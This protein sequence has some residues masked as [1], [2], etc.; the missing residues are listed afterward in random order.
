[1][2]QKIQKY[3]S[4]LQ[5]DKSE[6]TA[7]LETMSVAEL[8]TLAG[9]TEKQYSDNYKKNALITRLLQF[10]LTYR[11][12]HLDRQF[13]FN[14]EN[15]DKIASLDR[16]LQTFFTKIKNEVE[17]LISY[18]TEQMK[19][20]KDIQQFS[21]GV[22]LYEEDWLEGTN[23][24]AFMDIDYFNFFRDIHLYWNVYDSD[25]QHN[26]EFPFFDFYTRH[27]LEKCTIGEFLYFIH[28]YSLFSLSDMLCVKEINCNVNDILYECVIMK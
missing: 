6:F 17:K 9:E 20:N 8:E 10:V 18:H 11:K 3:L 12:L 16:Q 19:Q 25:I 28:K 24:S 27:E 5:Q 23:L 7:E 22:L 4:E 21:V 1:M 26:S 13:S 15:I 2:E 14:Q